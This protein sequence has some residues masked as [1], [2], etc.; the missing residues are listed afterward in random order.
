[1]KRKPQIQLLASVILALLRQNRAGDMRL[2]YEVKGQQRRTH[3]AEERPRANKVEGENQFLKVFSDLHVCALAQAH[4]NSHTL[5]P[6]RHMRAYT[7]TH[8]YYK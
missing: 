5:A 7:Q 6:Y 8:T 1:M 3:W 4:S 2:S